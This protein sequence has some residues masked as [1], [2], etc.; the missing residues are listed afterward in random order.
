M[1]TE[2]RLKG[3]PE[4]PSASGTR[5]PDS[6]RGTLIAAGAYPMTSEATGRRPSTWPGAPGYSVSMLA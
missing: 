2:S 1:G 4:Q 5:L 3:C 6:A